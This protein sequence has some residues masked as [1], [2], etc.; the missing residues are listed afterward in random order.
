MVRK[1]LSYA[2]GPF[3]VRGVRPHGIVF[4]RQEFAA[5]CNEGFKGGIPRSST[6]R[7]HAPSYLI[8]TTRTVLSPG[9]PTKRIQ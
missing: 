8:T 2:A 5:Q 6:V 9:S 7:A 1:P 3:L 4:L